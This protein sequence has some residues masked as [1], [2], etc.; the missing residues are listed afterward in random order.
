MKARLLDGKRI[1]DELLD[2][3]AARVGARVQ[4]GK[5]RPGLAVVL[6]GDEAA[7]AVYVRNKRRA[8]ARVGF[9]SM[10]SICQP[11]RRNPN[12]RR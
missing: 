12:W 4:A 8:C 1:A 5:V 11:T 7:S 3:L 10:I 2:R 9:A 6:V